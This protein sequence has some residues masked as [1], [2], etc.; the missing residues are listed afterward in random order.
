MSEKAAVLK[1]E[2]RVIE[3]LRGKK[4]LVELRDNNHQVHCVVAGKMKS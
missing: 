2:G 3:C 1:F 4:F